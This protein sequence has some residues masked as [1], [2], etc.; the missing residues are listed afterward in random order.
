MGEFS[1]GKWIIGLFIYFFVFYIITLSIVNTVDDSGVHFADPG[2]GSSIQNETAIDDMTFGG[3]ETGIDYSN[4]EVSYTGW[5]ATLSIMTGINSNNI[6]IGVPAQ[7]QFIFSFFLFWLPFMM[8]IW[9]IY[10]AIPFFH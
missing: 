4:T 8:L 2:F 7:W 10:M 3:N 9:A 5:K 6:S 1:A